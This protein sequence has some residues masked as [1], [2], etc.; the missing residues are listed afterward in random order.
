[1]PEPNER[2]IGKLLKA[3]GDRRREEAGTPEMHPAAREI[4]QTE[5]RR[6]YGVASIR[7]RGGFARLLRWVPRV[8]V[9][10]AVGVCAWL[11][12]FQDEPAGSMHFALQEA[13]PLTPADEG[14]RLSSKPETSVAREPQTENE[15]RVRENVVVG[16][17]SRTDAA[18]SAPAAA[19]AKRPTTVRQEPANGGSRSVVGADFF[20]A[21]RQA[22][23]MGTAA[24][25]A[26]Q[27]GLEES[28][29]DAS[30]AMVMDLEQADDLAG[31]ADPT[32]FRK[33]ELQTAVL[34]NFTVVN[35][36]RVVRLIDA[37]GS[38]YEGVL[39]PVNGVAAG[40]SMELPALLDQDAPTPIAST[41]SGPL[42]GLVLLN[43]RVV[44]SGTNRSLNQAVQ[45]EGDLE[46]TEQQV[47]LGR[48]VFSNTVL[49][50]TLKKAAQET[51]LTPGRLQ[52]KAVLDDG[53]NVEV[54][55]LLLGR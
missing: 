28:G 49:P 13:P 23:Y 6:V 12:W 19:P 35:D 52:G 25:E 42:D 27:K 50:V 48:N 7:R 5:V 46:L 2:Q 40:S 36:G 16:L 10:V 11:L 9:F 30:L 32:R 21:D 38:T 29:I 14:V 47:E 54:D 15:D 34:R 53:Q 3:A 45:F 4:L 26:E 39:H 44:A 43:Y 55:A 37:D 31:T 51:Q 18:S 20:K 8:A 41:A 17:E 22:I 33:A 24:A 1:M